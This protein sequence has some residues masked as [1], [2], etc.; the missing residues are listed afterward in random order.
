M[1][2]SDRPNGTWLDFAVNLIPLCI[3][4]GLVA[5]FLPVVPWELNRWLV[6]WERFLAVFAAVLL[7]L[8]VAVG[9]RV[10][11]GGGDPSAK[12]R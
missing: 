6:F 2:L 7:L 1:S 4:V 3:L 11:F 5:V 12:E 9:S 10:F 8:V